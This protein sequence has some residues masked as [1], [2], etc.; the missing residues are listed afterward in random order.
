MNLTV[1]W[2]TGTRL[3]EPDG[4]KTVRFFAFPDGTSMGTE[5]TGTSVPP[6][7]MNIIGVMRTRMRL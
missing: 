2:T 4:V 7:G 5:G 6:K 3:V 1:L